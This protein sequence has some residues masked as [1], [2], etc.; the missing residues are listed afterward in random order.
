MYDV[1]LIADKLVHKQQLLALKQKAP[2]AKCANTIKEAQAKCVTKFFWVV[3]PDL[4][5][6]DDFEFDYTPDKWSQEYVHVFLNNDKYDGVSLIP[7]DVHVT[8][9]E[10]QHR[11]FINKKEVDVLV[12]NPISFDCFNIENYEDYKRALE[13]SLTDMFWMSSANIKVDTDVINTFYISHHDQ[14]DRKQN[15]AFIHRVDGDDLYNGLF[16]CSKHLP[17][18]EK[19]VEYRFPV[20]RKEWDIIGSGPKKYDVFEIDSYQQYLEA[21]SNS[22]TEMFWMSS[23]NLQAN[24]PDL[25][26][27]HDNTHDRY[28]NHNFLHVADKRNGVFLCSTYLPL[29]QKEVEHR[30]LVNA[31]EWDIV[32]SGPA[33]YHVF[34]ID[35]YE[36]YLHAL[37]DSVTEMFYVVP[38]TVVI[39]DSFMFNDYFTHDNN[40]D[41]SINHC[42][43]NDEYHDGIILCSKKAK[44]SK[45][46]WLFRFIAAKKEVDTLASTPVPYDIVFISYE[47]P[48][49]DENYE[50]LKE[51]F[52]RAKRVHGVKGIHQAH[53]EAA[54]ISSTPM[55]W[56]VD[57][58]AHIVEAFT[59]E[60]QVPVWQHDQVFVWR[61]KNPVNSLVY[62]YGGVKLF[63]TELTKNMDISKPDMTTSISDKFNAIPIVSNITAF[64]VDGFN[65]WKSGFRECT[66]LSSKIIDRQK[67]DETNKRLKIWTTIGGDVP[68]GH[69]ATRGAR[70]GMIY[71]EQYQNS[72]EDLRKINDFDWLK[73]KYNGNI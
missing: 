23:A 34:Y 72:P 51:R 52:P 8:D 15:H 26:F 49:A 13:S 54:K 56:I 31:K 38:S 67:N 10:L 32:A 35:T 11:F 33:K 3:Y 18:T 25:Y 9:K 19:E 17:L 61:S 70:A 64:N 69:E 66:K 63:P 41:R 43:L 21:L 14:I 28:T 59:F 58:D 65:S 4:T 57:G 42:F 60:H 68:F 30:F 71:G 50:R 46:E 24:L 36:E 27:T 47:E 62:G 20:N 53:I 12:S 48:N 44:I 7:A 5:I 2:M 16:L 73:E 37:K 29:D 39:E 55:M 1:Y 22:S 6:V 45:R 40:F